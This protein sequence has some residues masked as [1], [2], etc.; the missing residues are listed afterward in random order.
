MEPQQVLAENVD[1]IDRITHGVCRR[2]GVASSDIDDVASAVKL[3]LVENDY[4]ILRRFQGRSSLATYLAV[5]VQRLLAN[6]RERTHGRW[7]A[8]PEAQRLGA[9]AVLIEDVVGRQRRSIEEAMPMIRA[10]DPTMTAGDAAAI[11]A[12]LPLRAPRPREV[13]LPE[14]DG[15][16]PAADRAD[17]AA[18]DGE[19]RALSQRA[20]TLLRKTMDGWP[21]NDRLL[22]RLRFESSL[23]IADIA[24]LMGVAQRPLYRRLETLLSSLREVL[25][26]AGIDSAVVDDL[27]E[28]SHRVDIN[29]HLAWK[30]D[31]PL[32]TTD[33]RRLASTEEPSS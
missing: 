25:L 19:M 8:S 32:R 7:R 22:V 26:S 3:A 9:P 2:S 21:A 15:S 12:R 13:P 28:A 6:Q 29:L 30:N 14:D 17:T 24:R 1:L 27:L 20:A 10:V 18:L 5:I 33:A 4:A 31:G 11:A 23:T 16:L